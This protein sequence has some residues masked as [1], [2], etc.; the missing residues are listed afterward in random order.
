MRVSLKT[1]RRHNALL[2][3]PGYTAATGRVSPIWSDLQTQRE[4]VFA[5]WQLFMGCEN[6]AYHGGLAD[7]SP[8]GGLPSSTIAS[9]K[10]AQLPSEHN[11]ARRAAYGFSLSH[12]TSTCLWLPATWLSSAKLALIAPP[13]LCA[14]PPA[15]HRGD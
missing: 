5:L 3:N 14:K 7:L 2:S 13:R 4:P 1:T 11:H 6:A 12:I 15:A 9:D 8:R 10:R